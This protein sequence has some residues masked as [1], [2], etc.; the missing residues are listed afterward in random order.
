MFRILGALLDTELKFGSALIAAGRDKGLGD[1]GKVIFILKYIIVY[2]FSDLKIII[3]HF[4]STQKSSMGLL[5]NLYYKFN[6]H[7]KTKQKILF[8]YQI[9]GVW[10]VKVRVQDV[11]L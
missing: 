5:I 1:D 2:C 3:S 9:L 4:T 11:Q 10:Q 8:S 6:L 7:G